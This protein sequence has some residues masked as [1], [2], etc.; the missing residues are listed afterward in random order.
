MAASASSLFLNNSGL[1][2]LTG[3]DTI[4]F[5]YI[6]NY[7]FP[8]YALPWNNFYT[9][10][11]EEPYYLRNEQRNQ[12]AVLARVPI[13]VNAQPNLILTNGDVLPLWSKTVN[14]SPFDSSISDTGSIIDTSATKTLLGK[15]FYKEKFGFDYQYVYNGLFA[16]VNPLSSDCEFVVLQFNLLN[17]SPKNK[18]ALLV[19]SQPPN[20]CDDSCDAPVVYSTLSGSI[21]I[22]QSKVVNILNPIPLGL[23][24][25]PKIQALIDQG[26]SNTVYTLFGNRIFI[27]IKTDALSTPNSTVGYDIKFRIVETPTIASSINQ[28]VTP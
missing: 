23:T 11:D 1:I 2:Q 28:A 7:I 3:I 18:Q 10:I 20:P 15:I 21:T 22:N 9:R 26:T 19:V 17:I 25:D 6:V 12:N 8:Q 13:S 16:G 27:A 5:D 24:P 4:L 14:I